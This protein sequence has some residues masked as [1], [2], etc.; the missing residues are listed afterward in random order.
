M[1]RLES[2]EFSQTATRNP[3]LWASAYYA[4]LIRGQEAD[5]AAH[6][7]RIVVGTTSCEVA[8]SQAEG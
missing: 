6:G 8:V 7:I 5:M 3:A 4:A 2:E 1:L